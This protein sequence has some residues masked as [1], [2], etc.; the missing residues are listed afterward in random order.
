MGADVGAAGGGA[1]GVDQAGGLQALAGPVAVEVGQM[2]KLGRGAVEGRAGGTQALPGR[3]R[4]AVLQS[5]RDTPG[6]ST[7][8]SA[9]RAA[10]GAGSGTALRVHLDGSVTRLAHRRN[11]QNET[12]IQCDV[13][14]VVSA[15]PKHNI[16]GMVSGGASVISPGGP[17]GAL[18]KKQVDALEQEA[19]QQAVQQAHA[20]FVELL[21]KLPRR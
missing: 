3:M 17:R 14:L 6:L 7:L 18:S 4:Q 10:D 11:A 20:S 15:L 13:S 1:R 2:G 16:V 12:E 9:A 5:V 19:L 8:T 21:K